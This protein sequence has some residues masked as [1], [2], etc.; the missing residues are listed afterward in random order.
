MMLQ[1]R[2]QPSQM[3]VLHNTGL[4]AIGRDSLPMGLERSLDRNNASALMPDVVTGAS[5]ETR[6]RKL[7]RALKITRMG[8]LTRRHLATHLLAGI[9]W[10][11]IFWRRSGK[12]EICSACFVVYQRRARLRGWKISPISPNEILLLQ[13][14][15]STSS[16][17]I[18]RLRLSMT[19]RLP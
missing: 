19:T 7:R 16:R 1:C 5:F 11:R 12:R 3:K 14:I 10:Q 2:A 15:S 17:N 9:C 13:R 18:L 4:S 8:N 6:Q